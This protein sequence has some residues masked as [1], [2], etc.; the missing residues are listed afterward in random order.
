MLWSQ[1]NRGRGGEQREEDLKDY[2]KQ[3]LATYNDVP[4]PAITAVDIDL[5]LDPARQWFKV[6]GTYAFENLL[7]EPLRQIPLT[8]GLHWEEMAL[9][10]FQ[11]WIN[12]SG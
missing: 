8:G 6:S 12:I 4:L 7:D 1:V 3:N 11:E 9:T 10:L 2:W 5:E